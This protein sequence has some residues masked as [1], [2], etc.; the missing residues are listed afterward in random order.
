MDIPVYERRQIV[1]HIQRQTYDVALYMRIIVDLVVGVYHIAFVYHSC[2]A[3]RTQYL[4]Y[5]LYIL[6]VEKPGAYQLVAAVHYGS[7]VKA[8]IVA[9][10]SLDLKRSR[11]RAH[12]VRQS[13]RRYCYY[14]SV[15][16]SLYQSRSGLIGQLLFSVEQRIVDVCGYQFIFHT[17]LSVLNC[18]LYITI[19]PIF[20]QVRDNSRL[21][22]ITKI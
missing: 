6:A 21:Y 16:L 7:A 10:V 12:A 18:H 14:I 8:H 5:R 19:K 3:C 9:A 20:W 13:A 2:S 17:Y 4:I 22:V 1:H 15:F 11:E